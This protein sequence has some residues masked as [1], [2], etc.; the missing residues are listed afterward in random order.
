MNNFNPLNISVADVEIDLGLMGNCPN[1]IRLT[2]RRYPGSE[3]INFIY[4]LERIYGW[5][6]ETGQGIPVNQMLNGDF[7]FECVGARSDETG[8]AIGKILAEQHGLKVL[9]SQYV[10]VSPKEWRYVRGVEKLDL[11]A[12]D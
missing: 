10:K 3:I 6:I 7:G 9:F 1:R 4:S 2:F 11:L 5:K 12:H 8:N